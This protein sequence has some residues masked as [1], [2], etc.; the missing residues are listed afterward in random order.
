VDAIMLERNKREVDDTKNE[1]TNYNGEN[2]VKK[3]KNVV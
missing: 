1:G 3:E 2:C